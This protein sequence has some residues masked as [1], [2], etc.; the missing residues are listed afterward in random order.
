MRI[1][2]CHQESARDTGRAN[3][4][5]I[6]RAVVWR[7]LVSVDPE[8][9]VAHSQCGENVDNPFVKYVRLYKCTM[10]KNMNRQ[11]YLGYS[12]LTF[13]VDWLKWQKLVENV[14]YILLGRQSDHSPEH[15]VWVFVKEKQVLRLMSWMVMQL[16][17]S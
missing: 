10:Y 1:V 14:D 3:K 17:Q 6:L 2:Y 7:V 8:N 15:F 16:R 11:Y 4:N 12:V 9:W 13:V 5:I